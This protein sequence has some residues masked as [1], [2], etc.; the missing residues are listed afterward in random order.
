MNKSSSTASRKWSLR[1]R[2]GAAVV[3]T[4]MALAAAGFCWRFVQAQ[5]PTRPAGDYALCL[6]DGAG[7]PVTEL[8]G[9]LRLALD[10]FT[11]YRNA[12]NQRTESYTIDENGFRG[13]LGDG[14]RPRVFV[15]GGSAAFGQDLP[16]DEDVITAKLSK[17]A[18]DVEIVNA[19][20]VGFLAGQE[21]A[22]MVHHLDRFRPAG[23]IA[24]DGWN[25]LFD[26]YHFGGRPDARLGFNNAFFDFEQRLHERHAALSG[27]PVQARPA[28]SM[29]PEAT[30]EAVVRAYLENLDRMHAFARARGACFL[31]AVQPEMGQKRFLTTE[32]RRALEAWNHAY[33]YVDRDFSGVFARFADRTAE[34]CASRDIPCVVVGRRPELA[35]STERLFLDPVHLSPAGSR[36]AARILAGEIDR[37][38][39][40]APSGGSGPSASAPA[41][42]GGARRAMNVR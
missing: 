34:Y 29:G 20:V 32:E 26:Q 9:T 4:A 22:L 1:A 23:Y 17:E 18:G 19:A 41:G 38:G 8:R 30:F 42:H 13:G 36:V 33:G 28:A 37:W 24:L 14:S 11:V 40:L 10:P 31:A 27:R 2:G 6:V 7:R 35:D 3:S 25:E 21:L 12:P 5:A 15:L 39:R 16:S